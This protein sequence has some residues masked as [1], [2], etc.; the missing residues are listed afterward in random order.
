MLY[1]V[2]TRDEHLRNRSRRGAGLPALDGAGADLRR[3]YYPAVQG[4]EDAL[5]YV[6]R[7][8]YNF[9]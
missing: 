7:L 5:V 9:V 6:R 3:G 2:I 1:E 8:S 4:R